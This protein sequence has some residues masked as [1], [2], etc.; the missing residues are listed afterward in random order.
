MRVISAII[1]MLSFWSCSSKYEKFDKYFTENNRDT[2]H[3]Y[4]IDKYDL[5]DSIKLITDTTLKGKEIDVDLVKHFK[6]D[7]SYDKLFPSPSTNYFEGKKFFGVFKYNIANDYIGYVVRVSHDK[8]NPQES[9][10]EYVY[11]TKEHKFDTTV[12]LAYL[13]RSLSADNDINSWIL[14]INKDGNKDLLTKSSFFDY[15]LMDDV[16]S[17]NEKLDKKFIINSCRYDTAWCNLWSQNRYISKSTRYNEIAA[18]FKYKMLE[19]YNGY[20]SC[21]WFE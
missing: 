8:V 9:I 10:V 20:R 7:S 13:W 12:F 21:Y 3:I 17:K 5:P 19:N 14:D 4:C 15:G 11:N 2:I 16:Y 1:I 18:C 6:L